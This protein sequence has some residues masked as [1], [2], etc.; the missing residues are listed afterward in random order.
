MLLV[1]SGA[2]LSNGIRQLSVYD[3]ESSMVNSGRLLR[4]LE[5]LRIIALLNANYLR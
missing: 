2:V 3:M 4:F 1:P 5:I